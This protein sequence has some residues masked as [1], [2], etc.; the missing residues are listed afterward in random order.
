MKNLPIFALSAQTNDNR[1]I[2]FEDLGGVL[3]IS[4]SSIFG[5]KEVPLHHLA[6]TDKDDSSTTDCFGHFGFSLLTPF[7][8]IVVIRLVIHQ[9]GL[10][11]SSRLAAKSAGLESRTVFD[12]LTVTVIAPHA[13]VEAFLEGIYFNFDLVGNVQSFSSEAFDSG[14]VDVSVWWRKYVEIFVVEGLR[15]RF[16]KV[17]EWQLRGKTG[18]AKELS[19]Q[20]AFTSF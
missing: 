3:Y 16:L 20:D 9:V 8:L 6:W 2:I 13:F 4:L 10:V 7:K 18:T 17:L 12:R 5:I 11:W 19:W 14:V 15:H 1:K